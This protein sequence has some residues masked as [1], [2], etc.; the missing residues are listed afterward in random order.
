MGILSYVKTVWKAGKEGGTP[1]TPDNLNNMENGIEQLIKLINSHEEMLMTEKVADL[2]TAT[3]FGFRRYDNT[4]TNKPNE[5]GGTVATF[6]YS[7]QYLT[8]IACPNSSSG[9]NIIFAR[10]C[11]LNGFNAWTNISEPKII[12][13]NLSLYTTE[14][15]RVSTGIVHTG[16][17]VTIPPKSSAAI[18]ATFNNRSEPGA[19]VTLGFASTK[20]ALDYE[21]SPI[22]NMGQYKTYSHTTVFNNTYNAPRALYYNMVASKEID[23]MYATVRG[24]IFKNMF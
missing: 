16:N 12:P 9:D 17:V 23:I 22:T 10:T 19:N 24:V 21:I 13:V 15:L 14:A 6:P 8:Q 2:N 5:F 1:I 4:A 3:E 11:G 20:T 18:T 7:G